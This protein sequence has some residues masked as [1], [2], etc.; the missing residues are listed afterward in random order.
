MIERSDTE[1][2]ERRDLSLSPS[3]GAAGRR[4]S[5]ATPSETY[6]RIDEVAKR[7]GL[8]KRTL[9][10]YEELGLL[11]PAQ[12]SEGNYRLFKV[13]D[14]DTLQRIKEMRDLLGLGL[15][16]I[17][18]MVRHELERQEAR[19]RFYHQD[20]TAPTRLSAIDDAER[21]T[22]EQLH[23][24]ETRIAAL[25]KMGQSLRERLATYE[26]LRAEISSQLAHPAG[27][28]E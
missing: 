11:D 14:L 4:Q 21:A 1:E 7:T 3:D 6:L 25:N 15:S 9:R 24:I 13:E 22:R 10:Y 17:R 20:A 23:M 5:E 18:E 12:R 19:S 2:M 26:R 28:V 16:E 27:G 8:T